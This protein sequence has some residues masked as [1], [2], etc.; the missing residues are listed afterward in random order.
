MA[1]DI[2]PTAI[3]HPTAVLGND[4]RVGPYAIIN[5]EAQI[6]DRCEIMAYAYVDKYTELAEGVRVFPG[7][8]LGTEPQDLKFGGEKTKIV[9]GKNTVVR[10]HVMLSR[11]TDYSFETR[12]GENCL[13]MA[14]VHLGHDCVVGNNVILANG[15]QV[16]GHVTIEDYVGLGGHVVV[17][18]FTR[19]GTQCF[20]E[21]LCKVKKDVPP[22]ILAMSIPL[23]FGG[24]NV[25]GLRRRGF[26]EEQMKPMKEAYKLFFKAG[27]NTSQALQKITAEIEATKE[28]KNIIAF[29]EGTERGTIR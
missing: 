23:T 18:Q 22:Y 15:V 1:V 26:S 3:V 25:V 13:L 14:Y 2:H 16:A 6:G 7:A 9:I 21:G 8:V 5:D 29:I 28:V 17:H 27:Y 11:G 10:E 12:I 24:L 4:V 20:I 19:I